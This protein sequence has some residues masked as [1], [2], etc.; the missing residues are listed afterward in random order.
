MATHRVIGTA[1]VAGAPVSRL[2]V[3]HDAQTWQ[4]LAEATSAPNDG[5]WSVDLDSGALVYAV[6]VPVAPH[7]PLIVGPIRPV[8]IE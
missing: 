3:I 8:P 4:R 1:R 2:V 7:G 5:S 6:G